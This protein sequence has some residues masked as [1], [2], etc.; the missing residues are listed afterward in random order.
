[1]QLQAYLGLAGTAE[2]EIAQPEDE[3]LP[4]DLIAELQSGDPAI[5]DD[6]LARI[7]EQEEDTDGPLHKGIK[8]AF[9][10]T[11]QNPELT[12]PVR[13][14]NADALDELEYLPDDLHTF[15]PIPNDQS[16][17]IHIGRYPVTNAQYQRFLEAGDFAQEKYWTNFPKFS[18]PDEE[19]GDIK[20]IG[21]WGNEGWKWL[22]KNWNDEKKVLPRYWNDSRFGNIR[23]GV[24]VVGITWYEANAYCKWLQEH[25]DELSEAEKNPNLNLGLIR[26]PTEQEWVLFSGGE[27]PNGRYP[28][29]KEGQVTSKE[30]EILRR[31]NVYESDIGRTTPV[32]MYP[33]GISAHRVWDMSGNVWEWQANFHDDNHYRLGLRGGAFNDDHKGARAASRHGDD[34]S[35]RYRGSG[36]RVMLAAPFSPSSDL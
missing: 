11:A 6:V 22:Q 17:S 3:S 5:I 12:P 29:D 21:D 34:P 26:L 7:G 19:T 16:P 14:A 33:L 36:V 9:L 8:R 30:E 15:V 27:D 25:W 4:S 10:Q 20:Q 28:W 24:P 13:A 32:A 2:Q 31:A 35:S 1:V 18:E 23:K